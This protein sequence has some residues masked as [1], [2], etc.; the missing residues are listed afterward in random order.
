MK[1]WIEVT[2]IFFEDENLISVNICDI[3]IFCKPRKQGTCY[4]TANTAISFRGE[5]D[6]T[7]FVK[8]TYDELKQKIKEASE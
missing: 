6:Q 5:A 8:E 4:Q 2:S 3:S 7:I 1:G